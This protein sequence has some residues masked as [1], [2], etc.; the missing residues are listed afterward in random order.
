M[1]PIITLPYAVIMGLKCIVS[2][3]NYASNTYRFIFIN[4]MVLL[5]QSY[6][7]LPARNV[8]LFQRMIS[9]LEH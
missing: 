1:G 7:K 8:T 4:I 5:T 9:G 6:L 3:T 2:G